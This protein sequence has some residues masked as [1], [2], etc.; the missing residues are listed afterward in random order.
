MHLGQLKKQ[1]IGVNPRHR[2]T[3]MPWS[4]PHLFYRGE[5]SDTAQDKALGALT[6]ICGDYSAPTVKVAH[7]ARQCGN[8]KIIIK[9]EEIISAYLV[10]V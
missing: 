8:Y 2:Y 9:F 7:Q 4:G 1:T 3:S 5:A 10:F 6:K